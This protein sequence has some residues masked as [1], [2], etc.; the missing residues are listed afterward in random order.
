MRILRNW[1]VKVAHP[2]L[3]PEVQRSSLSGE[4]YN[5]PGFEDSESIITSA[6]DTAEG[7]QVTTASGS[8]YLLEGPP[9]S[10]Y[11]EWMKNRGIQYDPENPIT[12]K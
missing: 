8:V 10:A 6:I 5:H 12:F 7:R 11:A 3:P 9:D 2:H 1:S 4:V